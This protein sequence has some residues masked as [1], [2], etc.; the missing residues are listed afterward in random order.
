M[1]VR[2]VFFEKINLT[3]LSLDSIKKEKVHV[4]KNEKSQCVTEI[5]RII[6]EYYKQLSICQKIFPI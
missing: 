3:N 4:K 5:Q 6:T 1:N 2:A